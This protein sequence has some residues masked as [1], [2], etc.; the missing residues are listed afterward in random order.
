MDIRKL[1]LDIN[2]ENIGIMIHDTSG[3][4]Q[5]RAITRTFYR[6]TNAAIIVYDIT[7]SGTFDEV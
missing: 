7:D 3:M 4:E 2:G 5:F 1:T 6:S